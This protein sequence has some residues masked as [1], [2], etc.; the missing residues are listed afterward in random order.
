MDTSGPDPRVLRDYA[1]GR[2]GTRQALE[3]AGLA[4][5]AELIIALAQHGL[6]LPK[7]AATRRRHAHVARARTILQPRLRHGS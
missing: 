7:P 1:E 2:L 6:E 4:D 5:F 3:R